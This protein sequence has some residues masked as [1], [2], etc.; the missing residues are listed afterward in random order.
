MDA[1]NATFVLVAGALFA[2]AIGAAAIV[3]RVV[4]LFHAVAT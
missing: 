2:L 4:A 1:Q 3:N